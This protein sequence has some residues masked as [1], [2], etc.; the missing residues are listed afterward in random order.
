MQQPVE[1]PTPE[2]LADLVRRCKQIDRF[3]TQ[4]TAAEESRVAALAS[5]ILAMRGVLELPAIEPDKLPQRQRLMQHWSLT[6]DGLGHLLTP[7][8]RHLHG[9]LVLDEH[10]QVKILSHRT[11]RGAWRNVTLWHDGVHGV[12][13]HDLMEYLVALT[14]AAQERAPDTA[15]ALLERARAIAATSE[16]SPRGPRS[17]AD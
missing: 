1:A 4:L 17:R 11:W 9:C 16:L 15:C 13:A 5:G 3:A 12:S 10:E 14:T 6:D 8:M 2:A 7:A